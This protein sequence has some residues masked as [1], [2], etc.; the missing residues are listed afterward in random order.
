MTYT[1]SNRINNAKASAIREIL[2][3]MQD[4]SMISFGGGNPSPDTFPV[5]TLKM[6]S[7]DL[8]SH[9]ANVLLE[10]GISEGNVSFKEEAISFFERNEKIKK[11]DD[12]VLITSGSQQIMDFVA[13]IFINE[14]DRVICENPSFLGALNA[15]KSNGAKLIGCDIENDGINI[16]QVEAALKKEVVKFIYVIPNFQNPTGITMS[17]E[18][19]KALY[20]LAVK[21]DTLI[22]EDNPY[23]DLRFDGQMIPSIKSLDECGRVIY[24]AS[25][26]KIIAPGMRVAMMVANKE[27]ISKA[28]V[29]KQV[30]DVH[31]NAW[32]Q[33]VM[34][35]FLRCTN[36]DT[37]LEAIQGVYAKK[38]KLM[39]SLMKESFASDVKWTIP[40]GGMFIWVTLPSRIDMES[41]V[42][43]ALDKKVAV[44]PGN[45]F[46]CDPTQSSNCFRMNF[47]TPSKENIEL[48]ISI[49]GELTKA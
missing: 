14:G 6:I 41:F 7:D 8:F 21:Y 27:I 22:L 4:P 12:E 17:L 30:N 36:M 5:E 44:V 47:S 15:F 46:L 38:A 9:N 23:G 1:F 43:A 33:A 16:E 28:V 32:A 18:K 29:A 45:A 11:Q 25:L 49:L 48:G 39:L 31:T 37:H 35:N 3:L 24:G 19:R 10:Y 13:K 40:S 42:K 2:K 26:S 34:A 20:A